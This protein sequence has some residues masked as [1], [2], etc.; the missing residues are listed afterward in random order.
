MQAASG[1]KRS[2]RARAAGSDAS[3]ASLTLGSAADLRGD[4]VPERGGGSQGQADVA[5]PT[6]PTAEPV[7]L[8]GQ[9]RDETGD[10]LT[11]THTLR[12]GQRLRYYVSNRLIAGGRDPSGC[13]LPGPALE[14]TVVRLLAAH[15]TDCAA[16]HRLLAAPEADRWRGWQGGPEASRRGCA[17]ER[18]G[19]S[20][21]VPLRIRPCFAL[22]W[23]RE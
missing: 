17:A 4:S 20:P 19:V 22:C 11:P 6:L 13:R 5:L 9:L 10:R 23:R 14:A 18:V 8:I 7:R 21:T 3:E 1:R 16:V 15:L 2:G 12:R